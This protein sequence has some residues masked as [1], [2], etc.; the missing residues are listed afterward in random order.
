MKF[1]PSSKYKITDCEE[2]ELHLHLKRKGGHTHR[3]KS[4]YR[5]FEKHK[6]RLSETC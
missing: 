1:K 5:R 4:G 2:M 6:K 3:D